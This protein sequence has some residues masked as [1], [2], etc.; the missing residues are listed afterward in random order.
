MIRGELEQALKRPLNHEENGPDYQWATDKILGILD[1]DPDKAEGEEYI[2]RRAAMGDK[3][4]MKIVA[5]R[6]LPPWEA[7]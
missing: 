1:W 4:C 3:T 2:R 6:N 5:E 7:K